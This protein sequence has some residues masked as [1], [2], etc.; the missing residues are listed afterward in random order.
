M[1]TYSS[2]WDFQLVC[3]DVAA[4]VVAGE[5]VDVVADEIAG[6]P[7]G[8]PVDEAADVIVVEI[9]G[10]PV[11]ELVDEVV[12][13]FAGEIAVDV[14]GDGVAGETVDGADE[15]SVVGNSDS[16]CV[17]ACS[18]ASFVLRVE[19]GYVEECSVAIVTSAHSFGSA[20]SS[21]HLKKKLIT[22]V[23]G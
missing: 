17:V 13:E 11:G 6:E 5:I 10:E 23:A 19:V 20:A 21:Y 2:S 4:G 3:S 1:D 22:R 15:E 14:V 8:E 12:G 16:Y 18:F 7:V 9:A